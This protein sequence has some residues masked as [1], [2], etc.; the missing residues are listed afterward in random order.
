[1][2]TPDTDDDEYDE[3]NRYLSKQACLQTVPVSQLKKIKLESKT[4]KKK[5]IRFFFVVFASCF[6]RT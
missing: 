5:S 6:K 1:M 4:N 3:E 2:T